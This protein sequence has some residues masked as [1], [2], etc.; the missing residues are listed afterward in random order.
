MMR[1]RDSMTSAET[2]CTNLSKQTMTLGLNF[3]RFFNLIVINCFN[4]IFP[5]NQIENIKTSSDE[6]P[7]IWTS[8]WRNKVGKPIMKIWMKI[9]IIFKF[10]EFLDICYF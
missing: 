7:S 3:D 9:P 4:K 2:D 10:V 8:I 6:K 5:A 1:S